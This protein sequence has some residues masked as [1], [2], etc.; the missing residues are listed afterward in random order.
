MLVNI[1]I[2]VAA[3]E[4]LAGAAYIGKSKFKSKFELSLGFGDAL[5]SILSRC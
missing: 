1:G 4:I 3:I 5:Q 2:I